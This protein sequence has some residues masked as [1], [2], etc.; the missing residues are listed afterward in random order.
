MASL[1]PLKKR[2][3][4][5]CFACLL[6]SPSWAFDSK[7]F[8]V[9]LGGQYSSLLQKRG[10]IT[11][12]GYQAIPIFSVQLFHPRLIWAG[13]ALYYTHPLTSENH[14]LRFRL[15]IDSTLDRPLYYTE[16][17]ETARVRRETT[18][19]WDVHYELRSQG[20]SHIRW[21][22]SKDLVAHEGLYSQIYSHLALFDLYKNKKGK[23]VVQPGLFASIGGG[24]LKHNTYLYGVGA[25]DWS[26][27][28]VQYGLSVTSPGVID[29]FWPTLRI[30]RFEI[31]GDKNR[32][33]AFVRETEGWQIEALM[34]FRVF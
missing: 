1:I 14:F 11:Y 17:E 2:I 20:G 19:E 5:F 23:V 12:K 27:T 9:A 26:L 31:L 22:L 21:E 16:E 29:S 7:H 10:I 30:T 33:A 32:T 18:S 25:D 3:L 24:D 34:A 6:T 13:S 4:L 8:A 28:N 15:N